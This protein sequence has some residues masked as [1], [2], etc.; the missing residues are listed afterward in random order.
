MVSFVTS[1]CKSLSG[2]DGLEK[3]LVKKKLNGGWNE[4]PYT[5]SQ[6]KPTA[7]RAV[8]LELLHAASFEGPYR[9]GAV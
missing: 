5:A 1:A 4:E 8:F 6:G 7:T 9:R 3:G 2:L